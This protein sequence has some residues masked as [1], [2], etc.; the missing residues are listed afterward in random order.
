MSSCC[1]A[2]HLNFLRCA[3]TIDK[4]HCHLLLLLIYP[5][6]SP[7]L[8]GTRESLGHKALIFLR[9]RFNWASIRVLGRL[10]NAVHG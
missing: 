9:I 3:S 6:F 1:I 10:L 7:L 5:V 4:D 8:S 2:R